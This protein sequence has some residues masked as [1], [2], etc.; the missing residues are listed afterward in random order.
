MLFLSVLYFQICSILLNMN[1]DGLW[2]S[3]KYI[4]LLTPLFHHHYPFCP[5]LLTAKK[6]VAK[7]IQPFFTPL[8][9]LQNFS[10]NWRSFFNQIYSRVRNAPTFIFSHR[11]QNTECDV[12]HIQIPSPWPRFSHFGTLVE[13]DIHLSMDHLLLKDF[14][15]LCKIIDI[16]ILCVVTDQSTFLICKSATIRDECN[17]WS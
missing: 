12:K 2:S 13:G 7:W 15:S 3:I 16:Q 6:Y 17:S 14:Y 8:P 11:V 9:H 5:T 1:S 4:S 10:H